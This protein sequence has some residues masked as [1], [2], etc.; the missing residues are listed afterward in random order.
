MTH[1][2]LPINCKDSKWKEESL[3]VEGNEGGSRKWT[4]LLF[5]SVRYV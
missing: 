5:Y 4:T 2:V 1:V 3:I